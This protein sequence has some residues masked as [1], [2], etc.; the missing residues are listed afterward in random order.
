MIKK[1][2]EMK[3]SKISF[4]YKFLIDTKFIQTNSKLIYSFIALDKPVQ[5]RK[6]YSIIEYIPKNFD[7]INDENIYFDLDWLAIHEDI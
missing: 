1:I 6:Y 5:R 3:P 7:R 4:S 2:K